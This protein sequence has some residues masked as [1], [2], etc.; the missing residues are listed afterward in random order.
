MVLL[1]C[2]LHDTVLQ[3]T[4]LLMFQHIERNDAAIRHNGLWVRDKLRDERR[5]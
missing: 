5:E 1:L 3:G 4:T 2:C